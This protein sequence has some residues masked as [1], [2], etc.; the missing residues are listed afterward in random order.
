MPI[1][2]TGLDGPRFLPETARRERSEQRRVWDLNGLRYEELPTERRISK[3][4]AGNS[5]ERSELELDAK[6]LRLRRERSE[7]GDGAHTWN[8]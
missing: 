2:Q 5:Y 6:S 7:Q 8:V 3:P 4:R 1:R